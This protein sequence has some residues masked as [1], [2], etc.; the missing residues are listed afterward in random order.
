LSAIQKLA[1][2]M[3]VLL[4]SGNAFAAK[5][6]AVE[7]PMAPP[8]KAT[9]FFFKASS[10]A[11]FEMMDTYLAR[12]ADINC[13]NCE[14]RGRPPLA[15]A[16]GGYGINM[17]LVRYLVKHGANVNLLTQGA[18][19]PLMFAISSSRW[20]TSVA[21]SEE[22]V[23]AMTYLVDNGA[24]VKLTNSDGQNALFYLVA[25]GYDRYT[26]KTSLRLMRYLVDQGTDVNHQSVDGRT[27]LMLAAGGCGIDSVQLLLFMKADPKLKNK[28]G[29]TALSIAED[30]AAGRQSGG[31]C[32]QVVAMLRDP[33]Q[34]RIN[35]LSN[36]DVISTT[37]PGVLSS[38][39]Q[40]APSGGVN[41]A[42]LSTYAGNYAGTFN[43]S[44]NGTFQVTIQ[45]NGTLTLDGYSSK[46]DMFTGEGKVNSDGTVTIGSAS[47]GSTFI[48]SISQDG[49]AGT[50]K[51]TNYNQAG[52][53]QG[54]KGAQFMKIQPPPANPLQAFGGF[55]NGLNKILAPQPQQ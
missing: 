37:Q 39:I 4:A 19:S 43:G 11:N 29:D 32:N 2:L 31:S 40:V 28:M 24:D 8:S 49:V 17:D 3:F 16:L 27:A 26:V 15:M 54:K 1:M 18:L 45:P 34:Y 53:F 5:H 30:T 46:G 23:Q 10:N 52:S 35:P 14:G 22:L 13:G 38:E 55:L 48:G 7:K 51:N 36:A 50:W 47:T 9:E 6:V 20:S 25:H 12:G 42:A 33:E 44:D 21:N 41:P